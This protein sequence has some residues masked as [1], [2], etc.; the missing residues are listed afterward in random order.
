MHV[1]DNIKNMNIVYTLHVHIPREMSLSYLLLSKY[2]T[3]E[4]FVGNKLKA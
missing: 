4:A 3:A 2:E 1:I